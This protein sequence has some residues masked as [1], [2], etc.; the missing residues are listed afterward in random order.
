MEA[1]VWIIILPLLTAFLLVI[2]KLYFPK[3]LSPIVTGSAIIY[4]LLLLYVINTSTYPKVY[5][6]GT[7]GLLGINLMVDP[8]AKMFLLII[9]ILLLPVIIF[10]LK[11]IKI[12]KHQY[13]SFIFL[14]TAGIAGMVLTTDLFNLY[15]FLEVSSLSSIALSVMKKTDRG[16]EGTFKYLI[17][18]TFG[19]LFILLATIL[20]YYVTGTLNMAE[21]SLE[22]VDKP[23]EI[24]SILMAFFV[25]GYAVKIGLIPFHSW[26]PDAYED[27]PIPYNVLSSGLVVKST[28][29]ALIKL[30]YIMFGFDFLDE[31]GLLHMG[32]LWGVMTFIVAHFLAYQQTNLVRLLAYSTIAQVA[33]ITIGLFVGSE[34]GLIGG[35]LHLFNHA[36][37]KGTLFLVAAIF[38]SSISAVTIKDLK[39]LGTKFPMISFTFVVASLAIVGLPP[40]NGFISKW[41]IVEAALQ[42]GFGY[43]AFFILVGTFLS[44]TYYLKVIVSLYTKNEEETL[45]EEPSLTL[46]LPTIFLGGLC[47]LFGIAPALPLRIINEIPN[48]MLDN[49]Q[50]IRILLGG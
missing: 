2:S 25:F 4:F 22:L 43:A 38:Y 48:F 9:A 5:S 24:K 7:W 10:S 49:G 26:V 29:Y 19:S 6:I 8:F 42:A 36:I 3:T 34:G 17:M 14:M 1:V 20:T 45:L 50:Y 27:S 32:V 11:Y 30:L 31:S 41:L 18:A 16:I 47:I 35:S 12:H 33:Y 13:F 15:V 21:I 46:R 39:G 37:M 40:F 28:V 44:L 23:F